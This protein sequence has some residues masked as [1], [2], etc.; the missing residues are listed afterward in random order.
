MTDTSQAQQESFCNFWT[1]THT[2]QRTSTS[3]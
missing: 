2:A 1:A 3:W